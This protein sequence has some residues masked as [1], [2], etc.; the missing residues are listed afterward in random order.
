[1]QLAIVC[2]WYQVPQAVVGPARRN[3]HWNR[4][5]NKMAAGAPS[6]QQRRVVDLLREATIHRLQSPPRPPPSPTTAKVAVRPT[7]RPPRLVNPILLLV[8]VVVNP[9]LFS[10]VVLFFLS[11]RL[12]P[13]RWFQHRGEGVRGGG[14]GGGRHYRRIGNPEARVGKL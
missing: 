11:S 3:N 12:C 1:M 7:P 14:R 6:S 10:V 4:P 8:V 13:R 2:N 5:P 9:I